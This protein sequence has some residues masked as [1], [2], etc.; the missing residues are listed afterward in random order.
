LRTVYDLLSLRGA[1]RALLIVV[2][3]LL[4]VVALVLGLAEFGYA[5]EG[6]PGAWLALVVL[7]A[8]TGV[9]WWLA[10]RI[11]VRAR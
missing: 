6:S 1:L 7:L 11:A 8:L 4:G 2:L 3:G 10:Y 5:M 9:S